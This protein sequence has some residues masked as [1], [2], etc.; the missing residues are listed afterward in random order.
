MD[1]AQAENR[2]N[3]LRVFQIILII[4]PTIAIILRF[5]S[6][7]LAFRGKVRRFWWDDWTALL[8]LVRHFLPKVVPEY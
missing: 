5:W 3:G 2:T 1:A 4:L 8:A 6:R 7:A